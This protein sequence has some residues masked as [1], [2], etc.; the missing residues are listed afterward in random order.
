MALALL[1]GRPYQVLAFAVLKGFPPLATHPLL[2]LEIFEVG[3]EFKL[4][5]EAKLLACR[6]N[7][8]V[9]IDASGTIAD[10]KD[11]HPN[12]WADQIIDDLAGLRGLSFFP[13]IDQSVHALTRNVVVL[14]VAVHS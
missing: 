9:D 11:L 1:L 6:S 8:L 10:P 7:E 5:D 13:H 14:E 12:G 4:V 3:E 2:D